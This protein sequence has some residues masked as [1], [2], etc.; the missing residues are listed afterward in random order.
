MRRTLSAKVCHPAL[1][2]DVVINQAIK[3]SGRSMEL[4]ERK[5]F[6]QSA[7]SKSTWG[8]ALCLSDVANT[9]L[10]GTMRMRMNENGNLPAAAQSR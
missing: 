5:G 8:H 1:S 3:Q 7:D 2:N 6:R 4:D 9:A 10:T